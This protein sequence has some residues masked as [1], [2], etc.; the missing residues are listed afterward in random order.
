MTTVTIY[1]ILL[2]NLL[3]VIMKFVCHTSVGKDISVKSIQNSDKFLEFE[4][5]YKDRRIGLLMFVVQPKLRT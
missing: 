1:I 3:L 4:K 2:Q 5:S